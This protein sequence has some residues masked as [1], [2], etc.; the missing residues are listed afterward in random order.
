M[1][2]WRGWALVLAGACAVS[3]SD[4][5]TLPLPAGAGYAWERVGDT[6]RDAFDALAFDTGGTPW[7]FTRRCAATWLDRAAGGAGVWR[8]PTPRP[9][10]RCALGALLLGPHPPGGP[11][12]ADTVLVAGI[13]VSRSTNAGQTW[14]PAQSSD[15]TAGRVVV[16]V[17][18]GYP[19]AG[20]LVAGT[21]DLGMGYS[22]DRGDTW[23]HAIN[24]VPDQSIAIEEILLLP[25]VSRLPGVASGRGAAAPPG[26]PTGRV[27]GCGPGGVV[28]SDTGGAGYRA[29]SW[30]G[31]GMEAR[32]LAL[33]RRPDAHPLGPGPRL[34]LVGFVNGQSPSAWTSDDVGLTWQRRAFL[35]EPATA[36][37][38]ERP[39]AL[40]ALSEAGETDPGAGGRAVAVMGAGHLYQTTDA[41]ETW[42]VIGRAPAM[43]DP[44]VQRFTNVGVAEMGPDGRLYIGVSRPGPLPGE[45]LYRTVEPFAVAGEAGPAPVE[46]SGVG[47]LVR[48]NPASGR[49]SV[50]LSLAEAGPVRV[51]VV[52]ALGREVALVLDGAGAA[53][54]TVVGVE[55][56]AWPAGLYLVRAVVPG[57]LVVARLVVAR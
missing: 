11:A 2:G 39:V 25:P 38:Y 40:F 35:T 20:R 23:T 28:V 29:T 50:V 24:T 19:H 49:V 4:A 54:E 42:R 51:A 34:L 45:W 37:G 56:G 15:S 14:R 44:G 5:Q 47:V 1:S 12:R 53:G 7:V 10:N 6:P 13:E 8:E 55:T 52:D 26:W 18:P 27:V 33:V 31:V 43:T 41:G 48:P 57:R 3:R 9:P 32:E 46:A 36:P 21:G 16:E 22:D 17:P 30:F